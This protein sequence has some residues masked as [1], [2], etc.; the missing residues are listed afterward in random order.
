MKGAEMAR[1]AALIVNDGQIAV[2][3]RPGSRR[4]ALYYLSPGGQVEDRES[5]D[6]AAVREVEE[7]FGLRVAVERLV[8][9][10]ASKPVL[11]RR[12]KS[13]RPSRIRNRCTAA[14]TLNQSRATVVLPDVLVILTA[15]R[16]PPPEYVGLS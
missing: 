1:A 8:A 2:I 3:E 12:S 14:T 5:P 7:E 16:R 15:H 9:R 4:G 13:A 10:G 11:N 6:A